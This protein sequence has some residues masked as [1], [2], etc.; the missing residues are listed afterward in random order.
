MAKILERIERASLDRRSFVQLAATVGAVTCLGLTGCDSKVAEIDTS[1]GVELEPGEWR[2]IDC[3]QSGCQWRCFNQAYVVDGVIVRQGIGRSGPDDEDNPQQ[4]TCPRG[5]SIRRM[6]TSAERLK[7]PMKRKNWQSGGGENVN[8]HLRGI[9]EWER[10]SWDEAITYMADE[11][12]RIRDTYGNRAFL[13][14]GQDD[15]KIGKGKFGS[16]ILNLLGGC[17]TTWGQQSEG[18][19]AV[20]SYRMRGCWDEGEAEAQ[21]RMALRHTKLLVLW[22]FN[23]AWNAGTGDMYY[24]ITAKR[25]AGCKVILIDP[26][27][28]PTAQALVDQ[29]IPIHPSTD[30]A[31]M[32]GICHEMI[33]NNWQDQD[34]LDRCCVGFD[35]AHMPADAKVNENFK[36][37]ILGTY[38]GQPKTAE[39]ASPVC[40]VPV[41]TIKELAREMATTKPMALKAALAIA[42][43]YYGN[44]TTQLFFTMGWMTGN[45]GTLGAEV[46]IGRSPHF[47]TKDGDFLVKRGTSTYQFPPNPACTEP[48]ADGILTE[49]P[50]DPGLEYGICFSEI[51]KAIVMG[52]YTLPGP[53]N[54]KRACD[55]KCLYRENARNPS[56][57]QTGSLYQADAYRK[58]EF[59]VVQDMY[60]KTD[61]QY[62]DIVLPVKSFLELDFSYNKK[63]MPEFTLVAQKVIEPYYESLEDLEIFYLLCDKLGFSEDVAPRVSAKQCQFE[64]LQTATVIMEDGENREPLVAITRDDLDYYGV[65]GEPQEGRVPIREFFDEHGGVYQVMR[66]DDD[67]F[68][69]V[70]RKDFRENP[71]DN[72]VD[73]P[74]GKCEIY[75]QSLKDFYDEACMHDIDALPKY[76]PAVDGYEQLRAD[77]GYPFQLITPHHLRQ[78]HSNFSNVKQLNEVFPNDLM[79]SAYDAEKYGL[80]RG[81]WVLASCAEGGKLARRLNTL[82]NLMPG[83]VLLGEG[84]WR[85]IDEETGIDIGGN[86][87]T[88]TRVQYLGDGYQAYNTVLLMIEK[89]E[90]KALEPDYRVPNYIPLPEA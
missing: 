47:G 1:S 9:D 52:E 38:D 49:G 18:G 5:R 73:T 19:A 51:H 86:P 37:Y 53:A 22:G 44:R 33:I 40:G 57:Q 79:M 62:A 81:D 28:N 35:A 60:M 39:W 8:G 42:R 67:N 3:P 48:R 34:F 74:S 69:Q 61:A 17:L 71:E 2:T 45:V 84:N 43:T 21:D 29:W 89:Y 13:A 14:T 82:P 70:F 58:L 46:S 85:R 6:V 77:S 87:N 78:I 63:C 64:M 76:K 90:G 23:A 41:E 25:K 12:V 26:Y 88:V 59:V 24:F 66:S 68:K 50:F 56:N 75:C 32:E 83:V 30:G 16:Q 65:T 27:F 20:V 55:I 72:P 36:D 7:Y 54:E 15:D 31:M 10:V 11:F 4:R 80:K